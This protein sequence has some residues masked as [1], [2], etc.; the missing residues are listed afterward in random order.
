MIDK[1]WKKSKHFSSDRKPDNCKRATTQQNDFKTIMKL[2]ELKKS[3]M[4]VIVE[5]EK[6]MSFF[7]A[8]KRMKKRS[9]EERSA[10]DKMYVNKFFETLEETGKNTICHRQDWQNRKKIS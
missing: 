2:P 4:N 5:S 1:K 6:T 7:M 3:Q 9:A 8:S 10:K